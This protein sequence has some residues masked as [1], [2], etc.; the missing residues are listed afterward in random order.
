MDTQYVHVT[1]AGGAP[2]GALLSVTASAVGGGERD[3]PLNWAKPN[4]A[5]STANRGYTIYAA[6]GLLLPLGVTG[7]SQAML[8]CGVA[9]LLACSVLGATSMWRCTC[10]LHAVLQV[11]LTCG[12]AGAVCVR[13]RRRYSVHSHILLARGP[14]RASGAA[15]GGGF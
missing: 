2:A 10:C 15:T 11:F 14:H 4:Q 9:V 7:V 8:E 6:H 1:Q 3:E 13:W 12:I 5:S